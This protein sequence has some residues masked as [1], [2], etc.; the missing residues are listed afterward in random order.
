MDQDDL[1]ARLGFAP[2]YDAPIPYMQ[3][4]REYYAAIGYTTPYRWAHYIDAPF[5]PLRKPLRAVARRHRHHRRAVPAGQGRPG[6]GRGLQR[7][8]QVLP[9]LFRRHGARPR[10]A[11]LAYRLRPRAHQR[12]GQRHLVPAARAAPRRRR[13]PH[14]RRRAALPRRADQPQP[15][16]H[17]RDRRAGNPAPR[18]GGWRGRRRSWCRTARSATRP[19]AWSRGIWRR[20]ASPPC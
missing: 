3:R 12:R 5:T 15:S 9:G 8:R 16:R 14:R 17:D 11:H 4:T 2:D 10:P 20:T 7:R 19:A 6:A 13:R 18:A 1:D